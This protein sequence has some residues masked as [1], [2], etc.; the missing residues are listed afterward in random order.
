MDFGYGNFLML[1]GGKIA[2]VSN[3]DSKDGHKVSLETA[4]QLHSEGQIVAVQVEEEGEEF[5]KY[6]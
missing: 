5:F 4:K 2:F 3:I 6:L 1:K